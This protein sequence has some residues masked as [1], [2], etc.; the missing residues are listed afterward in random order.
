MKSHF[1]VQITIKCHLCQELF[2]CDWNGLPDS[3]VLAPSLEAFKDRL[4]CHFANSHW[5]YPK[6]LI[7]KHPFFI[8]YFIFRNSTCTD[9]HENLHYCG[10]S[11]EEEEDEEEEMTMILEFLERHRARH[12]FRSSHL[13]PIWRTNFQLSSDEGGQKSAKI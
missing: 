9:A 6:L 10:L 4:W 3:V 12:L 5:P 13:K 2:A 8:F 7:P 1:L 11:E